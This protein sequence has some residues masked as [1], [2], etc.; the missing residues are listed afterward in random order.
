[1]VALSIVSGCDTGRNR[2]ITGDYFNRA[3]GKSEQ[4]AVKVD[5]LKNYP[6]HFNSIANAMAGKYGDS[7][8]FTV[9]K[10]SRPSSTVLANLVSAR[11]KVIVSG[12]WT[13]GTREFGL[14]QTSADWTDSTQF[15]MDAYL[16][17]IGSPFSVNADTT[18]T[19][20]S[21]VFELNSAGLDYIK[22][23]S[24]SG[25]FLLTNTDRGD[26]MMNIYTYYSSSKPILELIAHTTE[27]MD[28]TTTNPID[29][30]YAYATG[31]TGSGNGKTAI[32]SDA[33]ASGFTLYITLPDSF[34]QTYAFNNGKMVF[35]ITLNQIPEN[36]SMN[37]G[38]YM[39]T[40]KFS[41]VKGSTTSDSYYTEFTIGPTDTKIELDISGMLG[42]WSADKTSNYGILFK[43]IKI[44]ST[45][46]QIA[47]TPPRF[48]RHHVHHASGGGVIWREIL[49]SFRLRSSFSSY[50]PRP[51]AGLHPM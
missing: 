34:K 14:Y 31:I 50:P 16:S 23:W 44:A 39:L 42:A 11:L 17:K 48:G 15:D 29:S 27:G 6:S 43:P 12:V 28:T 5:S 21:M 4:T 18:E 8:A 32:I 40:S 7:K 47:L 2:A 49:A 20:S 45:P 30:A 36:G 26:A 1:M 46:A 22:S 9:L 51:G 25:A 41:T 38:A 3:A 35:P 13:G 19:I 10:F 33:A 37:F 24:T